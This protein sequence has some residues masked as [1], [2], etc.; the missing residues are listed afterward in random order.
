[1]SVSSLSAA[2][3]RALASCSK[4]SSSPRHAVPYTPSRLAAP[5]VNGYFCSR[6]AYSQNPNPTQQ[7][8]SG[9]RDKSAVGVR[10]SSRSRVPASVPSHAVRQV[11]TPKA[12][13]LFVVTGAA[14]FFY[15][16]SEKEKLQE[17]RRAYHSLSCRV[18]STIDVL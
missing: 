3:F 13:A 7:T 18:V 2:S 6:R 4:R 9:I 8:S 1:M 5:R 11:F 16:Q 14:L 12:S 10:L 17:Q 15:F